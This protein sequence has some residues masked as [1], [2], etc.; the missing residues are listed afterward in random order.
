MDEAGSVLLWWWVLSRCGTTSGTARRRPPRR[1]R[2]SSRRIT[3]HG[4]ENGPA[5]AMPP[6][7]T[8][9]KSKEGKG[10]NWSFL[11]EKNRETRHRIVAAPLGVCAASLAVHAYFLPPLFSRVESFFGAKVN[12]LAISSFSLS[13]FPAP[14]LPEVRFLSL[15][16]SIAPRNRH[17]TCRS[18]GR[19]HWTLSPKDRV[20]NEPHRWIPRRRALWSRRYLNL[21]MRRQ[22]TTATIQKCVTFLGGHK[23]AA[24]RIIKRSKCTRGLSGE[25]SKTTERELAA[26]ACPPNS[27]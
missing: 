8:N 1:G 24:R 5:T 2:P 20:R 15:A 19:P 22:G 27:T 18:C 16:R 14:S 6:A 7:Q 11:G 23:V 12:S 10:E 4:C 26:Y 13:F 25:P 21:A 17:R 3:F 9:A